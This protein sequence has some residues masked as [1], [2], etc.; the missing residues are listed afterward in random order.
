[1]RPGGTWSR[2]VRPAGIARGGRPIGTNDAGIPTHWPPTTLAMSRTRS[3]SA[4]TA[5][6]RTRNDKVQTRV[7]LARWIYSDTESAWQD[8]DQRIRQFSLTRR[9]SIV[10]L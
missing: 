2:V 5:S 7:H 3:H 6:R 8:A 10:G 9:P 4:S 1:M